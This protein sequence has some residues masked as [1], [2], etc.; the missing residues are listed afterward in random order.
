[1]GFLGGRPVALA[2][3]SWDEKKMNGQRQRFQ[4][5][6]ETLYQVYLHGYIDGLFWLLSHSA[7][8][9]TRP[10]LIPSRMSPKQGRC[11]NGATLTTHL[12]PYLQV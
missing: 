4:A 5:S 8:K 7:A 1:M 9:M 6:D 2:V 11:T 3:T 12:M 10:T